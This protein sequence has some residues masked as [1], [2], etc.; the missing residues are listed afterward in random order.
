MNMFPD[1]QNSGNLCVTVI[2][3]DID[4]RYFVFI[5]TFYFSANIQSTEVFEEQ[6]V[7]QKYSEPETE[8]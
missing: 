1:A 4:T 2:A 6:K 8:Y 3:Q 5:L 7:N